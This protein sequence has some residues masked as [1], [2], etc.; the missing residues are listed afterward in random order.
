MDMKLV[1]NVEVKI[2]RYDPHQ[3]GAKPYY[4]SYKVPVETGMSVLNVLTYI[5]ENLDHSLGFYYSCR[6]GKCTGCHVVVNGKVKLACVTPASGNM[7]IDPFPRHKIIRDLVVARE[8]FE[9]GGSE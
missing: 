8:K 7:K 3:K 4:Q 9:E 2:R 1:K 5:Y 6:I